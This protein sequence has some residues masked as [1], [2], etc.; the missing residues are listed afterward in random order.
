M[1]EKN[2]YLLISVDESL[3]SLCGVHP[4]LADL[5]HYCS[6]AVEPMLTNLI[7]PMTEDGKQARKDARL[8]SMLVRRA[9][10]MVALY[11]GPLF[12]DKFVMCQAMIILRRGNHARFFLQDQE[13]V[14][15]KNLYLETQRQ[16]FQ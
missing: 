4:A 11:E 6:R 12:K 9:L 8:R 15:F 7:F 1:Q 13:D 14:R 10:R 3:P 2:V 16:V 5:P